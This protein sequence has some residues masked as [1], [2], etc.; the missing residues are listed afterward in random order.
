MLFIIVDKDKKH[1]LEDVFLYSLISKLS[2]LTNF[3]DVI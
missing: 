2:K 3:V 1:N